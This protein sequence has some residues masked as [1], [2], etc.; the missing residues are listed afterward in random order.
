MTRQGYIN[1]ILAAGLAISI[2]FN[3]KLKEEIDWLVRH[4]IYFEAAMSPEE[5]ERFSD[6][7]ELGE[8]IFVD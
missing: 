7:R 3:V 6:H 1:A 5:R 8:R 4:H 2:Y